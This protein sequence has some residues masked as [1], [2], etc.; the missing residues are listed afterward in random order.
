MPHNTLLKHFILC[1]LLLAIVRG[2][3]I[4]DSTP[5]QQTVPA[6]NAIFMSTVSRL[7][8][9]SS[10]S[11]ILSQLGV[12]GFSRKHGFNYI[13]LDGWTCNGSTGLPLSFWKNPNAYI[14]TTLGESDDATRKVIKQFYQA[15]G[16]KLLV[17]AFGSN[18]KPVSGKLDAGECASELVAFLHDYGF[19]G[20]NID[21]QEGI[22]GDGIGWITRFTLSLN[23][24][25]A[26]QYIFSHSVDIDLFDQKQNPTGDYTLIEK[27]VGKHIHFYNIRY[28]SL[29][30]SFTN[31]KE[32]FSM[33]T[34]SV[35]GLAKRGFPLNKIIIGKP[36]L[37]N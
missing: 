16:V 8:D 22:S 19:D 25:N 29:K 27:A 14:N 33:G 3:L 34:L 26:K 1:V 32:I 2:A 6:Q 13:V 7:N 15:A 21:L 17:N 4:G 37:H 10:S 20:A 5:T 30:S 24:K 12:P 23:G 18:E 11:V 28:V 35:V 9:L 31:Y 36:S